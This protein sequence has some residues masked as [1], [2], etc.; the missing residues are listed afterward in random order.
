METLFNHLVLP[1]KLPGQQDT[2]HD[3]PSQDFF[4]RLGQSVEKIVSVAPLSC[5]DALEVLRRS[6]TLSNMVNRGRLDRG[7]LKKSFAYIENIPLVLRIVE[8][9]AALIIRADVR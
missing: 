6:L 9:N 8:Q 5:H 4:R 3:E 2:D 1:P 7:T